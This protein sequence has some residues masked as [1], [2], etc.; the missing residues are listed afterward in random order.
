[1]NKKERLERFNDY[2][3]RGSQELADMLIQIEESNEKLRKQVRKRNLVSSGG[4]LPLEKLLE[5]LPKQDKEGYCFELSKQ[6]DHNPEAKRGKVLWVIQKINVH[7]NG[8]ACSNIGDTPE[9]A[10]TKMLQRVGVLLD[11][12]QMSDPAFEIPAGICH[13][14]IRGVRLAGYGH[15]GNTRPNASIP[16]G[17]EGD[18]EVLEGS[19]DRHII[20]ARFYPKRDPA[21]NRLAGGG[22]GLVV[23]PRLEPIKKKETATR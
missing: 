20:N 6:A 18:V 12:E 9:E 8:M 21:G 2:S 16:A 4:Y 3:K 10:I 13:L 15:G 7:T 17:T 22:F 23:W 1:M 19:T 5:L 11:G 14:W